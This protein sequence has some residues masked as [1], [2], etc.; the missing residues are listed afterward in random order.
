MTRRQARTHC[1]PFTNKTL[2]KCYPALE[3][4]R[5]VYP[6][7]ALY[8][9]LKTQRVLTYVLYSSA[10][11]V[12]KL[13]WFNWR[14]G[15]NQVWRVYTRTALQSERPTSALSV[16]LQT[17][18]GLSDPTLLLRLK[19][20]SVYVAWELKCDDWL[21][22]LQAGWLTDW[23]T[24]RLAG[25]P[26]DQFVTPAE[27]TAMPLIL[28]VSLVFTSNGAQVSHHFLLKFYSDAFKNKNLT[29]IESLRMLK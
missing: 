29:E 9:E 14:E 6:W 24:E 22:E 5:Q 20:C 17:S 21:A 1:S 2:L 28:F 18:S 10:Q 25:W 4:L 7:H 13:R 26:G 27:M 19:G 12:Q 23:L 3:P 11:K 16:R 15:G 8:I